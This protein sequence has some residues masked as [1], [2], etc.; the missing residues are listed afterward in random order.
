VL[1]GLTL[2][3]PTSSGS[4]RYQGPE[5][6][7]FIN[8]GDRFALTI[9]GW[10]QDFPGYS[11]SN[12]PPDCSKLEC[13]GPGTIADYDISWSETNGHLDAVFIDFNTFAINVLFGGL[14]GFGL[15]GGKIASDNLIGGCFFT[16]CNVTG[17]WQSDLAVPEPMSAAL[18][19]TGLLGFGL[20]RRHRPSR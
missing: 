15:N 13:V 4:A 17:F 2:P 7:V 11:S 18:L 5:S 10:Y 6:Q 12:P 19:A 16:T 1:L 14:P 20:A 8:T 9:A 3:G